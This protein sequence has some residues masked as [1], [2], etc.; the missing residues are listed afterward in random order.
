MSV[1]RFLHLLHKV[2]YDVFCESQTPDDPT[3][4]P[5]IGMIS[6]AARGDVVLLGGA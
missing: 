2:V 1:I 6:S 4:M 3:Y 5:V